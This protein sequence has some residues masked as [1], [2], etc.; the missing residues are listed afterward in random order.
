MN[1]KFWWFLLPQDIIREFTQEDG[2]RIPEF[3][4]FNKLVEDITWWTLPQKLQLMADFVGYN[5]TFTWFRLPEQVEEFCKFVGGLESSNL[6]MFNVSTLT[7]DACMVPD[8]SPFDNRLYHDGEGNYPEI[9][10]TVFTDAAGT[11]LAVNIGTGG[12]GHLQNADLS[13]LETDLNGEV[14]LIT[15]R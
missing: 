9:G 8:L 4:E 5:H 6:T 3:E 13:Y 10:D 14:T 1:C 11:I 2:A 7:G 15:C 12:N